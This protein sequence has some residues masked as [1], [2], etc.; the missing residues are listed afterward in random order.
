MHRC[1]CSMHWL[2][3]SGRLIVVVTMLL[4]TGTSGCLTHRGQTESTGDQMGIVTSS[5]TVRCDV[6]L[7]AANIGGQEP[8]RRLLMADLGRCRIVEA[9]SGV[10]ELWYPLGDSNVRGDH[11]PD[12][13]QVTLGATWDQHGT[14]K[15]LPSPDGR[16]QPRVLPRPSGDSLK[17]IIATSF[18]LPVLI[19]QPFDAVPDRLTSA[20]WGPRPAPPAL[21][22]LASDLV[23]YKGTFAAGTLRSGGIFTCRMTLTDAGRAKL[24]AA[25]EHAATT[26]PAPD[27][28]RSDK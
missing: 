8:L 14:L 23:D 16:V 13:L 1:S 9:E 24:R 19:A 21:V 10:S 5:P 28:A 2:T 4:G 17:D 20:L 15:L 3:R 11:R 27:A 12:D 7:R 26:R 22:E 6:R 25:L 18:S